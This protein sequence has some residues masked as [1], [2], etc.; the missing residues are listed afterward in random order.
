MKNQSREIRDQKSEI[1]SNQSEIRNWRTR[2]LASGLWPRMSF[3][4]LLTSVLCP[5]TSSFGQTTQVSFPLNSLFGGAAYNKPL[6]LTAANTLI[7]DGQ[8]LWA[9]TYT[10]VPASLTN[11]I[12]G[13][14]P[15]TYLLTVP[16]VVRPVRFTVPASTNVLDVTTLLTS[17]PLFYF[18]TNGFVNL[19]ASNNIVLATNADGSIS[20]SAT[21]GG[22][23]SSLVITDSVAGHS[24]YSFVN[25]PEAGLADQNGNELIWYAGGEFQFSGE[26]SSLSFQP[27]GEIDFGAGPASSFL[28]LYPSGN[29]NLFGNSLTNGN[30]AG[31]FSGSGRY[32]TNVPSATNAQTANAIAPGTQSNLLATALQPGSAIS[33][34]QLPGAVVTNYA[35]A[36]I[37]PGVID[38]WLGDNIAA[39][40]TQPLTDW[41]GIAGNDLHGH[42]ATMDRQTSSGHASVFFNNAGILTNTPVVISPL[43]NTWTVFLVFRVHKTPAYEQAFPLTFGTVFPP[44]FR[45]VSYAGLNNYNY[46]VWYGQ[47]SGL[48]QFDDFFWSPQSPDKTYVY[49]ATYNTNGFFDWFDGMQMFNS[50]NLGTSVPNGIGLSNSMTIGSDFGMLCPWT[51]YISEVGLLSNSPPF[52]Q[53]DKVNVALMQ[54]YGLIKSATINISGDSLPT[55]GLATTN[56]TPAD[57]IGRLIPSA[58]VTMTCYPGSTSVRDQQRAS[59][60]VGTASSAANRVD[61]Q[62]IDLVNGNETWQTLATNVLIRAAMD[63]ANGWKFVMTIPP[64][65]LTADSTDNSRS[66]FWVWATNNYNF[67]NFADQCVPFHIDPLVGNYFA[68][69]NLSNY[70]A[71][72][73]HWTNAPYQRCIPGY[74]V[75]ALNNVL[76]GTW[77]CTQTS[78][79]PLWPWQPWTATDPNAPGKLF[80]NSNGVWF[81]K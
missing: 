55:G 13:L 36:Y 2:R 6:T 69:L 80:V 79:P 14:Y 65:S 32:L 22:A 30:F 11:P 77:T 61:W 53:I 63:H 43:T 10:I 56:N 27:S 72:G 26:Y 51:G 28:S 71:D 5:L 42:G 58:N 15:N 7:S 60:W 39:T 3:F 17:G 75:P 70:P 44:S 68:Y 48:A 40:N 37:P 34:A 4:V 31:T 20:I 8:N 12:I 38:W 73:I 52:D 16:G 33:L 67:T 23:S 50:I 57:I 74:V 1:R 9:G 64:S 81:P 45:L 41:Y 62:W 35:A 25:T 76:F 59:N 46:P 24:V 54:K 66:N 19:H 29:A 49:A 21:G 47:I 18:G 78:T